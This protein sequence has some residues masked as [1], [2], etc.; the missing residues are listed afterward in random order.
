[1]DK[2]IKIGPA[3]RLFRCPLLGQEVTT[4]EG[5]QRVIAHLPANGQVLHLGAQ[6]PDESLHIYVLAK[7]KYDKDGNARQWEL[8]EMQPR[9]FIVA[10]PG[11]LV[12]D[13]YQFRA[14]VRTPQGI[15]FLF[16][17]IEKSLIQVPGG[18]G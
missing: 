16:E 10:I 7:D 2:P 12:P 17:K 3:R 18:R 14:T 9:E 8:G 6:P 13:A 4:P 1:M 5:F 15:A 11:H